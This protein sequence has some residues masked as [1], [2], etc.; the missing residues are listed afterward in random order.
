MF[1][2]YT[3]KARR[4][5]FFARYEASQFGSPQ[6]ESEHVLYWASCARARPWPVESH[7]PVSRGASWSASRSRHTRRFDKLSPQLSIV[8]LPANAR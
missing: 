4:T 1:E 6:I 3:E 2:R 5:I 8:R 7:V